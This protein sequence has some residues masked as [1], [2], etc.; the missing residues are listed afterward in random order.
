[1]AGELLAIIANRPSIG[2]RLD[3]AKTTNDY[4]AMISTMLMILIIGIVVDAALFGT[5]ERVV[6]QRR[7]LVGS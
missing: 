1:M 5:V 7:G 6:R 2:T 3:F 4:V